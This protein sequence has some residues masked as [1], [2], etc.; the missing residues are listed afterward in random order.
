MPVT[1]EKAATR[2]GK[3]RVRVQRLGFEE[4]G[5]EKAIDQ[6]SW[7]LMDP[8]PIRAWLAYI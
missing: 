6:G 2:R 3:A 5:T 4:W 8:T 7:D 1:C